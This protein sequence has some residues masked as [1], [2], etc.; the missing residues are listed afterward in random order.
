MC[1]INKTIFPNAKHTA[2]RS[3]THALFASAISFLLCNKIHVFQACC[4]TTV[5]NR[6]LL[7]T[8]LCV[9]EGMWLTAQMCVNYQLSST[10]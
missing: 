7:E 6:I 8:V 10:V 1:A 3:K 2:I 4:Q 5:S 9:L